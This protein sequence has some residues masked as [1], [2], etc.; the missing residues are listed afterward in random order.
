MKRGEH[1]LVTTDSHEGHPVSPVG[2]ARRKGRKTVDRYLVGIYIPPVDKLRI[3][4]DLGGNVRQDPFLNGASETAA[5][6][7]VA[8]VWVPKTRSPV[9]RS[10]WIING[11]RTGEMP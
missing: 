10:S 6:Y 8:S 3:P 2:A 11:G 5:D 9:T 4:L 1:H 7:L